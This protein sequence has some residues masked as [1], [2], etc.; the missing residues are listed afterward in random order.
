ML[1]LWE[2]KLKDGTSVKARFTK[3]E[4]R[5]MKIKYPDIIFYTEHSVYNASRT[6]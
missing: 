3:E 1:E 6:A 4:I 2:F 5:E